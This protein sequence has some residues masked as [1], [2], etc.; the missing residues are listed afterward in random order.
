MKSSTLLS[1]TVLLLVLFSASIIPLKAD[2]LTAPP[3]I[4]GNL[5]PTTAS[6]PIP[7]IPLFGTISITDL[8]VTLYSVNKV[9]SGLIA[10]DSLT[11]T[12]ETQQQLQSTPGYWT[13]G[14]DAPL[15]NAP[16]F[17]SRDTQ[18]FH[19]GVQSP[20]NGT[21]AGY[22]AV[23]PNT[24]AMLFHSVVTTPDS[25]IPSKFNWFENGMYVQNATNDVNYVVCTSNTS[26]LGTQWVV[27]AANGTP[28]GATKFTPLWWSNMSPTEPLTRDCTIVT[29]GD[30][31]LKVYLDGSP[32]YSSTSLKLNMSKNLI[33]FLEP[34]TN[35]A[36]SLLG[37]TFKKF[38]I[39]SGENVVVTDN[40]SLAAK[41]D[42]VQP[43][44]LTTGKIL[45][46]SSVDS[47]GTATLNLGYY[48]M[49]VNAYIVVYD[50][51]GIPIA[52]TSSPINIFGG[53]VYSVNLL[54][55]LGYVPLGLP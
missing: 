27:S 49:P 10:S 33:S 39:T 15:E 22:Y 34:Q 45:A 53:D 12:T 43:T 11:D 18:G 4:P 37:G 14:G 17:I 3:P 52:S 48:T 13:Y 50:S 26:I 54:P 9:D 24:Q 16:Y 42:I 6:G 21:W 44:S 29:N 1:A 20:H 40:P 55:S 19:I 23:T 31:Y 36:G 32:V 25:T 35:Y 8:P 7:S 46:T 30:N 38:Y 51:N 5:V 28:Y 47:S 41:V 2:A